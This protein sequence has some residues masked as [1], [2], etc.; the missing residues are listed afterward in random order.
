M[1]ISFD[2]GS[3][4]GRLGLDIGEY[5]SGILNAKGMTSLFGESISTFLANPLLGVANLAK[6]AVTGITHLI[7]ETASAARQFGILGNQLGVSGSTLSAWTDAAEDCGTSAGSF[8]AGLGILNRNIGDAARGTGPAVEAFRSLGV[9]ITDA[10]GKTRSTESIFLDVADALSGIQ[11]SSARASLGADLF[12]RGVAE[13][14]PFLLKG[15]AGIQE[16]TDEAFALGVAFDGQAI[17]SSNRFSLALKDL[18]DVWEGFRNTVGTEFIEALAPALEGIADLAKNVVAPALHA[19][20]PIVRAIAEAVALLMKA[21]SLPFS[22]VG[23]LMGSPTSPAPK[24]AAV[25]NN[26]NVS[27]P[28]DPD[29]NAESIARRIAP[30]IGNAARRS[31][32]AMGERISGR[33]TVGDADSGLNFR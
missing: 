21:L 12:G 10:S 5:T 28:V 26:Y 13:I 32:N 9:Q 25:T 4:I 24:A 2:A 6:D 11:D 3:I 30:A 18:G 7:G 29:A 16:M 22:L 27:V 8:N 23:G 33:L 15:R 19:L 31:S 1:G 17:E 14:L 20:A